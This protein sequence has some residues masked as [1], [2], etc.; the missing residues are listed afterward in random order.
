MKAALN[1][2][3]G[4]KGILAKERSFSQHYSGLIIIMNDLGN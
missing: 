4:E 3:T 1:D 2:A